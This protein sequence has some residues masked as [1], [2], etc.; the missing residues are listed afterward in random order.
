MWFFSWTMHVGIRLLRRNML[1]VV[2]N[3]PGQ[4]EPQISRQLNTYGTWWSS[5]TYS[6]SK[7]C[8]NHCQI[9][10]LVQDVWYNQSQDDIRYLPRTARTSDVSPIE[11]VWDMMKRELTLSPEPATTIAKLRNG[12]KMFGTIYRRMTF[13]TF[14]TVCMREYTPEETT[15]NIDVTVLAALTVEYVS[16]GLNL[17]TYTPTMINYLS[18]QFPIQWTCPWGCCIFP[19]VYLQ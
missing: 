4:Q 10:K 5:G 16:F 7:T 8:H 3:C 11:H 14:M 17:L 12:C 18:H 13:G 6:F 9:A 1:S 15:L 19:A 2:Y